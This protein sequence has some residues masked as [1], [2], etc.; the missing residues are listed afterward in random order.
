VPGLQH[1]RN[2][3]L[4]RDVG[5]RNDLSDAERRFHGSFCFLG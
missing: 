3:R 1:R 2:F 4:H 5:A